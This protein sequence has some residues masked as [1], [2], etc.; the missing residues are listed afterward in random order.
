MNLNREN[1]FDMPLCLWI[2]SG[3]LPV[4]NM[5]Q[6]CRSPSTLGP[7]S[8]PLG[9][10]WGP[11]VSWPCRA[12]ALGLLWRAGTKPP[13]PKVSWIWNSDLASFHLL[14][15]SFFRSLSFFLVNRTA[16]LLFRANW[17]SCEGNGASIVFLHVFGDLPVQIKFLMYKAEVVIHFGKFLLYF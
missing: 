5:G 1:T 10:P 4:V 12:A 15:F 13:T 8:S 14:W 7:L 16:N 17:S 3:V 6:I 9:L 11:E 2:F